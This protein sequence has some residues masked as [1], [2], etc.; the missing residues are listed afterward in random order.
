M[1]NRQ[2]PVASIFKKNWIALGTPLANTSAPSI[3]TA[4]TTTT[5]V[6]PTASEAAPKPTFVRTGLSTQ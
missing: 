3:Q 2:H 6:I 4:T 1:T 5:L